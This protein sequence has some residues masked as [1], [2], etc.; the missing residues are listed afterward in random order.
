MSGPTDLD[1]RTLLRLVGAGIGASCL[2]VTAYGGQAEEGRRPRP[3]DLLVK[4]GDASKTPL[5]PADLVERAAPILVWAMEPAGRIVRS[6]S[7]LNQIIL[8]RLPVEKLR[9][10]T[11]ERAAEGVVAYTA[12]CTHSGCETVDWIADTLTLSCS[13]HD[14]LFDPADDA[15]VLSGPAPKNLPALPLT[16]TDGQ[17]AVAA[18][19][20]SEITFEQ[21]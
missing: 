10:G 11:K 3:G 20:T 14:S 6:G 13:C 16:V 21:A 1:R 2:N 4:A 8:M 18:P 15:M 5:K 17:L 9:P 12:I 19:F 7:R